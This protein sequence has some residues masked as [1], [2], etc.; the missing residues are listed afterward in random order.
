MTAARSLRSF[1]IVAPGVAFVE[2]PESNWVV[3]CGDSVVTL[4]DAGYPKDIELVEESITLAGALPT[5][6]DA[7]YITHGHSDHIG[8]IPELN[9]RY[10]VKAMAHADEIAN[11]T[12]TELH[13][14]D[15]ADILPRAWNRRVVRWAIRAIRAGGLA[16]QPV[17][18]VSAIDDSRVLP[19]ASHQVFA[20]A[21]PGHSPGHTSY[22]LPTERVVAIGDAFVT[23]HPTTRHTGPQMLN[24]M[25]HSD[26]DRARESIAPLGLLDA[27]IILP[28][29]GPALRQPMRT[30]TA[31]IR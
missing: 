5:D 22:F 7:V 26:L 6:L 31:S 17:T 10:G 30:A 13:Q 21:T 14:V 9:A 20:I 19:I 15:I 16:Q 29:H 23:A 27:D 4:I 3:L 25:F 2:G 24:P 8:A 28:G 1:E 12:R 11:V 18:Y